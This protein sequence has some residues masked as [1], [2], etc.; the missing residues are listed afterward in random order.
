M[1]NDRLGKKVRVKVRRSP[2]VHIYSIAG[3]DQTE[4]EHV[5]INKCFQ[6]NADDTVGDLKKLIA[7]QI[8][9]DPAKIKLQKVS[10]ILENLR[11]LP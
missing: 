7:A 9:T 6:C 11:T 4:M 10:S 8:G 1:C 5:I 3:G 2:L